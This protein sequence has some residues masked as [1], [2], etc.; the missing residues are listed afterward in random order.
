MPGITAA[1]SPEFRCEQYPRFQVLG[2]TGRSE[3]G[4][5]ARPTPA[6]PLTLLKQAENAVDHQIE[7]PEISGMAVFTCTKHQLS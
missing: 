5:A 2:R 6:V 1:L 7:V 4:G 3:Y